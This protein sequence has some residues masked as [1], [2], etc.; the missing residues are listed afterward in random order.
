M[1]N[2]LIDLSGQRFGKL[3]VIRLVERRK[4]ASYWLCKCDCGNETIVR[5]SNHLRKGEVKSCGCYRKEKYYIHGM[6]G[7]RPHRIWSSMKTR[8]NNSNREKYAIYGER[9]IQYHPKWET[10]EGFWEDMGPTYQD[11]LTLDRI[12]N[13]GNYSKDNC[14]WSTD[15]EQANNRSNNVII[16]IN[17]EMHTVA[18]WAKITGIKYSTFITRIKR[19][20]TGSQLLRPPG[21]W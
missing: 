11:R 12:D 4:D 1:A 2:T 3:T 13:N 6:C 10:F 20:D 21:R 16:E 15:T 18:Q 14:K 7:T 8:C 17:G 19:G 5:G 9:G